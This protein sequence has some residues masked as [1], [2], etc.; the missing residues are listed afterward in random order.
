MVLR[1]HCACVLGGWQDVAR[2]SWDVVMMFC[3]EFL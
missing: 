1:D 3:V 2:M